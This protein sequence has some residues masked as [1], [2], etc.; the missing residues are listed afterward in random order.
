MKGLNRLI[1]GIKHPTSL[2]Y[3]HS[4]CNRVFVDYIRELGGIVGE[5]TRF[6]NPHLCS[7]DFGR[8]DYITIG[9]NCC[10]S[11]V[12][13][14]AHDYSWYTLLGSVGDILPDA[15]GEIIIGN[16][17]FIGYGSVI[18]KNTIIGDNVIIGARA[19]VRGEIPSNTVWAGVPAKMICTIDEFYEKKA[20]HRLHDA[21]SRRDHVRKVTGND[22]SVKDMGLF[23]MLFLTRTENN[24]QTY[25]KDIEFNGKKDCEDVRK[26]FFKSTPIFSSFEEFLYYK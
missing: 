4:W 13:L 10:L 19:V 17:C 6:I 8:A 7:F 5:N 25:I 16:N 15:G 18:L 12:T 11:T 1:T 3:P 14:L 24:Y 22:P 9:N 2:I 20:R 26:F 21:L 23:S